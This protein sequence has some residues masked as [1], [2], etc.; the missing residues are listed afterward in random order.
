[1]ISNSRLPSV[2]ASSYHDEK[3]DYCG[4]QKCIPFLNGGEGSCQHKTDC[5]LLAFFSALAV[6]IAGGRRCLSLS[7]SASGIFGSR[8]N[9]EKKFSLQDVA[10]LIRTRVCQR[11]VIMVGAGISTPSGIPDF[12]YLCGPQ[13]SPLTFPLRKG[14][15]SFLSFQISREWSIQQPPAVQHPVP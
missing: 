7:V 2:L 12:R 15:V 5:H 9:S 13:P 10:E 14:S 11:V 1:M 3:S 4:R 8:G 6:S